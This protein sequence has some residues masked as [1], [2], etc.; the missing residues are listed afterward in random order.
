[1]HDLRV[2]DLVRR[3]SDKQG[4]IWQH[5]DAVFVVKEAGNEEEAVDHCDLILEGA[6]GYWC[7]LN[8]DLVSKGE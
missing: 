5:G 7:G 6:H 2:G 1:M 8:F 4:G 3:K